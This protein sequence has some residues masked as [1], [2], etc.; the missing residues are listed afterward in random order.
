MLRRL[1]EWAL[2]LVEK[3]HAIWVMAAISFAD[4]SFL[5]L[6]PD[7]LLIPMSV[8]RPK[9]AL[10]YAI[11]CTIASVAGAVLGYAIGAFL[12][13]TLGQW[14]IKIYGLQ[15]KVGTFRDLYAQWGAWVI[16]IKGFTPIPYKLVTIVSGFAGYNFTA[17][18][19]LSLITRGARFLAIAVVLNRFGDQVRHALD[20]H[21]TMIVSAGLVALFGG[22]VASLYFF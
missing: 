1:Y 5:P 16:I 4:S 18:I 8:A 17:F 12:W 11:V 14:I 13:D 20:R 3:P 7:F 22:V 9:R 19:L 21:L 10:T 6:P 2:S 15:G